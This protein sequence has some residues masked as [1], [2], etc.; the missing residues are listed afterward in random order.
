VHVAPDQIEQIE[1]IIGKHARARLPAVLQELKLRL[2]VLIEY[3]D[4]VVQDNV[5]P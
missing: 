3:Y 1:G 5:M 2:P 4:P